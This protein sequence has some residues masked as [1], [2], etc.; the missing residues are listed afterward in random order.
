MFFLVFNKP[1]V[2]QEFLF[3]NDYITNSTSGLD[4][5][6][7]LIPVLEG[8][9]EEIQ[10]KVSA[11]KD[12]KFELSW[13]YYGFNATTTDT[14]TVGQVGA[15]YAVSNITVIIDNVDIDSMIVTCFKLNG[16]P[17]RLEFVVFVEDPSIP[18]NPCNGTEYDNSTSIKLRRPGKQITQNQDILK[19]LERKLIQKYDYTEDGIIIDLHGNICGCTT[20]AENM[21]SALPIAILGAILGVLMVGFFSL[22]IKNLIRCDICKTYRR[23]TGQEQ[24]EE[25]KTYSQRIREIRERRKKEVTSSQRSPGSHQGREAVQRKEDDDW[26]DGLPPASFCQQQLELQE[27]KL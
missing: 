22:G 21:N 3:E 5:S 1:V 25:L 20:T 12:E 24:S 9:V 4:G 14:V 16:A 6:T 23:V 13:L 26:K 2:S 7:F 10:C 27:K 17:L 18:C 15:E 19:S 11:E 8:E